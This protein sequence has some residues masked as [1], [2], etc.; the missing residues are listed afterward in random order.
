[1]PD[2][3]VV[4]GSELTSNPGNANLGYSTGIGYGANPANPNP[5]EGID[6]TLARIQQQDY[7]DRTQRHLEQRQDIDNLYKML[8]ETKGSVFNMKDANGNNIS[9]QPLP[10]DNKVL[11]RK[12]DERRRNA[13]N[14][15]E[16]YR[17][18]D[19]AIEN[20][21]ELN[22]L[23]NHA[24]ARAVFAANQR[25]LAAQEQDP[26]ERE[27]I[28]KNLDE[29][30][31]SSLEEG[32]PLVPYFRQEKIN[33]DIFFPKDYLSDKDLSTTYTTHTADNVQ[34]D[35]VGLK[36]NVL[37]FRANIRKNAAMGVKANTFASAFVKSGGFTDPNTIAENNAAGDYTNEQRGWKPGSP[38]YIKHISDVLQNGQIRVNTTDPAEITYALLAPSKG[39]LSPNTKP[40]DSQS[41]EAET[42]ARIK[43]MKNDS[44]LGWARLKLDKDKQA[45]E[46]DRY[47][48]TN[49]ALEVADTFSKAREKTVDKLNDQ[50]QS[51]LIAAVRSFNIDPTKTTIS[52]LNPDD[53]IIR[54]IAGAK[55][56]NTSGAGQN[57]YES[58]VEAYYIKSQDGIEGDRIAT[59]IPVKT[60]FKNKEGVDEITTSYKWTFT[61]LPEAVGNTINYIN[62]NNHSTQV[63]QAIDEAINTA[64]EALGIKKSH[65]KKDINVTEDES[66]IRARLQ[67]VKVKTKNGTM[68]NVLYDPIT[69]KRYAAE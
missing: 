7:Q 45:Q 37:D 17:T 46:K 2:T 35:M 31:K 66:A 51:E 24:G 44:A 55:K 57:D 15:P 21:T 56:Y 69:Q 5:F 30:L 6:N 18:Q 67:P 19:K 33:P 1:M 68:V 53:Q 40:S 42:Q 38:H 23:T 49:A 47:H 14:H 60:K 32:A 29:Q 20:E 16:T 36:D 28:L 59:K 13:L 52:I 9:M 34:K 22:R 48:A 61:A 39:A 43:K 26:E 50:N 64:N 62:R 41:K 3:Q 54:Q 27:G 11:K 12:A 25:L 58:P 8:T 63:P 4:S 10:D 65:S